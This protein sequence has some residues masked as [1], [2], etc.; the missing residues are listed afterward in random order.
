M[1]NEVYIE[2]GNSPPGDS[3]NEQGD[4]APFLQGASR[5]GEE[6]PSEGKYTTEPN[7]FCEEGDVLITIRAGVGELNRADKRYCIGRGIAAL[8]GE[9]R[10][11]NDYLHYYLI[12]LKPYWEKVSSGSTY[13]SIT[14]KDIKNAPLPVPPMEEQEAIVEKLDQIFESIEEIRE[15]QK[16]AEKIY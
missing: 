11:K 4:G 16:Q 12:A 7:K 14:K 9:N 8:R 10:I 13:S 3:Y 1:K 6:Y 5:F 15:A 2:M